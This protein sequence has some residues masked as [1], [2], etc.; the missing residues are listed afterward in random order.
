[1]TRLPN[2][3]SHTTNN[4]MNGQ[5]WMPIKIWEDD[6][7]NVK[8]HPIS[9]VRRQSGELY[10]ISTT[11]NYTTDEFSMSSNAPEDIQRTTTQRESQCSTSRPRKYCKMSLDYQ[12]FAR[13]TD[14]KDHWGNDPNYYTKYAKADKNDIS[15]RRHSK[16]QKHSELSKTIEWGTQYAGDRSTTTTTYN[17]TQ[18]W[19]GRYPTCASAST[20]HSGVE[21]EGGCKG[22]QSYCTVTVTSKWYV[23]VWPTKGTHVHVPWVE[24]LNALGCIWLKTQFS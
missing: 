2:E 7:N 22:Y 6:V 16:L 24:E 11:T 21:V 14:T 8:D 10:R 12:D 3:K 18:V 19:F 15:T 20:S 5:P 1:M 23:Y 9:P 17:D 4:K 13:A